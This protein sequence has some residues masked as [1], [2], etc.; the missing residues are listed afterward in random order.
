MPLSFVNFGN[1]RVK[2]L[3]RF[4]S[5]VFICICMEYKILYI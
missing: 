1:V 3:A 4:D 2:R 5:F